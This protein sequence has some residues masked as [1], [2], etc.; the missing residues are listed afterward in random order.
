ME[1]ER[2]FEI[3]VDGEAGGWLE[4]GI[5]GDA[6]EE[7]L[8]LA[9]EGEVEVG[10]SGS[11]VGDLGGEVPCPANGDV[12]G[13]EGE[14]GFLRGREGERDGNGEVQGGDFAGGVP[15]PRVKHGVQEVDGRRTEELGDEEV[16]R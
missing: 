15:L 6:G 1:E 11:D 5:E 13:A 7:G 16:G 3:E 9:A 10:K 8:V 12:L 14:D 4:I 2:F